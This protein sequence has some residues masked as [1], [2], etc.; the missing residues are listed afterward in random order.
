MP[1]KKC[2]QCGVYIGKYKEFKLVS[3]VDNKEITVFCCST[4][5]TSKVIKENS[6]L[7]I[8]TYRPRDIIKENKSNKDVFTLEFN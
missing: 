7:Q 6:K 1:S 8:K 4:P 3:I 2:F 5:C